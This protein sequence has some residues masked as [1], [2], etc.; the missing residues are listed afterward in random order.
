MLLSCPLWRA[1]PATTMEN[2]GRRNFYKVSCDG[3]P[4]VS[5]RPFR[6]HRICNYET[7]EIFADLEGA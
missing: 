3:P 1:G 5:I 7:H 2:V 4:S 6:P